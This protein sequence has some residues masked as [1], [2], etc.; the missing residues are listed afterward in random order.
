MNRVYWL[1]ITLLIGLSMIGITGWA[2]E[3]IPRP[4][5]LLTMQEVQAKFPLLRMPTA[6]PPG[7][8][9]PAFALQ[10]LEGQPVLSLFY[11]YSSG[12]EIRGFQLL[13]A[14]ASL[15]HALSLRTLAMPPARSALGLIRGIPSSRAMMGEVAHPRRE[16][17]EGLPVILLSTQVC[18]SPI[19]EER[20][21]H[22][23]AMACDAEL[24][25]RIEGNMEEKSALQILLSALKK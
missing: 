24:C 22:V 25:I 3:R 4:S 16:I 5:P 18:A 9:G 2:N 11:G 21:S 15:S 8:V 7:V 19:C 20:I 1:M 6:L 12:Q 23:A 14:P 17:Y 10:T 13:E